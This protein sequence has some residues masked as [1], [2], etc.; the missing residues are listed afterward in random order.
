MDDFRAFT[1]TQRDD[2]VDRGL[3]TLNEHDLPEGEVTVRV[4]WSS[5]NY[6]DA[7]A[8]I[9][10]GGVAQVSPLVPG[11]DLA[12][13]VVS[14]SSGEFDEGQEVVV[15]GYE[16][17][18]GHHGGYAEYARVPA[19][20]VV[21]LPDGLSG[22]QAMA[23]GTAGYTAALSVQALEDHGVEPG[24][25]PVLVLGATGGVGSVAVNILAGRGYEVVAATGKDAEHDYLRALGASEIIGR[26]EVTAES[27]RPLESQRWA[28][29]VD[30]IGGAGTAYVL[31]TLKVGGAVALS[32]LTA[33]PALQTTVLPFVLRGVACLGVDSV[34]T[35]IEARRE[36]WQRLA[37][38]LAAEK[39]DDMIVEV[40]LDD[41]EQA[42]DAVKA[43]EARGR[44]V[45]RV[46]G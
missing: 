13:A 22:R 31:R 41:V 9:P 33:G 42:L 38:D 27:K 15:H 37:G 18:V 25:G 2:E 46:S 32:G 23:L 36:L 21:P 17:G 7:L 4:D 40:G 1:A 8:T 35:P 28:G 14:D 5:V 24:K 11:I 20:W 12:G 10:K 43:G 19:G 34:T 26:D 39:L 6:K 29:A 3:T 45:V 30:P 16:M 44:Q